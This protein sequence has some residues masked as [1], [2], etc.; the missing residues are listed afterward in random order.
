MLKLITWNAS[1]HSYWWGLNVNREEN[2]RSVN[3]Y[4]RHHIIILLQHKKQK[5]KPF[6]AT[7]STRGQVSFFGVFACFFFDKVHCSVNPLA[8]IHYWNIHSGC[9]NVQIKRS[10]CYCGWKQIIVKFQIGNA[11]LTGQ[12]EMLASQSCIYYKDQVVLCMLTWFY[13]MPK[14]LY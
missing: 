2:R 6:L 7:C 13:V 12:P 10:W 1:H 5:R 3:I 11:T 4:I 14:E 8:R 9:L